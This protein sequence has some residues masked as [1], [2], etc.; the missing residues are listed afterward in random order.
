MPRFPN[1]ASLRVKIC[2]YGKAR[3]PSHFCDLIGIREILIVGKLLEES[4][5]YS[6]G[7]ALVTSSALS[8]LLTF[9][10]RYATCKLQS[11]SESL[12]CILLFLVH[13]DTKSARVV[14][15]SQ[16]ASIVM[17]ISCQSNLDLLAK[18]DI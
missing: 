16:N 11:L 17:E 7:K 8:L 14:A 9:G 5:C 10:I 4:R 12:P 6:K 13:Q 2:K 3:R 1:L 15:Q 18:T